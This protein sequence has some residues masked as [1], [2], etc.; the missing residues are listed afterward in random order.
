MVNNYCWVNLNMELGVLDETN[1]DFPIS[2]LYA[3]LDCVLWKKIEEC[4]LR[5]K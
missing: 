3:S 4:K 1:Q 5:Q 2:S